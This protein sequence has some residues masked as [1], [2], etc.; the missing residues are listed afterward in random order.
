MTAIQLPIAAPGYTPSTANQLALNRK[1]LCELQCMLAERITRLESGTK[2]RRLSRTASGE[3]ELR[4]LKGI[5][6]R[7]TEAIELLS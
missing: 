7:L 2:R 4:R 5:D 1:D 6:R 3:A